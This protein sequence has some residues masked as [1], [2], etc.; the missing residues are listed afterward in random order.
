VLKE[1]YKAHSLFPQFSFYVLNEVVIIGVAAW[2]VAWLGGC[3]LSFFC[4]SF[5]CLLAYLID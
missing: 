4:S 2:L 5:P 3:L 1:L